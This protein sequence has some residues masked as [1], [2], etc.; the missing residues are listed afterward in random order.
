MF[1]EPDYLLRS[2]SY[3]CVAERALSLSLCRF[4]PVWH[5]WSFCFCWSQ[6]LCT[7]CFLFPQFS[8]RLRAFEFADLQPPSFVNC[9]FP[10]RSPLLDSIILSS[11]PRFLSVRQVISS[12]TLCLLLDFSG[13]CGSRDVCS[14]I[15]INLISFQ[16][17]AVPI[18]P[19]PPRYR[20]ILFIQQTSLCP[21]V[22]L[23]HRRAKLWCL[24]MSS[25]PS[26]LKPSLL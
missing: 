6:C 17:S 18:P 22:Q 3:I 1:I 8:V 15:F 19:P 20:H 12:P 11:Y 23:T 9:L 14:S 7:V 16:G 21:W 26:V 4:A 5:S 2:T 24:E 25:L 13:V 10:N